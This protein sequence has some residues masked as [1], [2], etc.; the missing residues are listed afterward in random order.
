[1]SCLY[2]IPRQRGR[3]DSLCIAL[4]VMVSIVIMLVIG[5]GISDDGML[6][7]VLL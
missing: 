7:T 6:K 2:L 1:M 5:S 3:S 4:L